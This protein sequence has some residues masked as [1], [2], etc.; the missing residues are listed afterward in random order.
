MAGGQSPAAETRFVTQRQENIVAHSHLDFI[1]AVLSEFPELR[2]DIEEYAG[3]P[4]LQVGEFAAFTQAAKGRGDLTTYERCLKLVD[5]MFT[6]A[7]ADLA[8]ALR[9]SYL[10]HLD[11]EGSRGPAA[12]RLLSPRLQAAWNQ[13]AAENRRLMAL[14]QKRAEPKP[15]SGARKSKRDY[16]RRQRGRR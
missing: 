10:E 15:P 1:S 12:W 13:V 2:D 8:S 5:G 11:F 7:D 9:V 16:P 6:Q 3:Q 4:H 14:P